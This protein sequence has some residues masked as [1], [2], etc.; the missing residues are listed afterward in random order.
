MVSYR[1]PWPCGE[2]G[3]E[4]PEDPQPQE[5]IPLD[6]PSAV[7]PSG[8]RRWVESF[9]VSLIPFA[10]ITVARLVFSGPSLGNFS[11]VELCFAMLSAAAVLSVQLLDNSRVRGA[12][13][14]MPPLMFVLVFAVAFTSIAVAKTNQVDQNGG[15]LLVIYR[16][17]AVAMERAERSLDGPTVQR[18]LREQVEL[19]LELQNAREALV[20]NVETGEKNQ[21]LSADLVIV[22][23]LSA[24]FLAFAIRVWKTI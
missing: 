21:A 13:D 22:L 20:K 7:A 18:G 9:V 2:E 10:A 12:A 14:I 11:S 3:V 1:P 24:G 15:E 23:I 8:Q 5:V 16:E 19:R 4:V 17:A 6:D